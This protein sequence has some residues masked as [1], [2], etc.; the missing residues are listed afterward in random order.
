VIKHQ[1]RLGGERIESSPEEKD[2]QALVDE[3]L[4]MT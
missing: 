2:V 3:K 4:N 1:Y